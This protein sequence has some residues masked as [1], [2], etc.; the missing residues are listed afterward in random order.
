MRNLAGHTPAPAKLLAFVVPFRIKGVFAALAGAAAIAVLGISPVSPLALGQADATL[1]RGDPREAANRYDQIAA[2]NP[3]PSIRAQAL[4]RAA[5]VWSVEL[6]VPDSARI[7]LERLVRSGISGA[8]LADT[9]EAIGG[10]L[11]DQGELT[12]AGRLYRESWEA[13]PQSPEAADRLIRSAQA[14]E[15]AGDTARADKAWERVI[16]ACPTH[17]ARAELGR[18]EAQL[19]KG[20][21]E[22]ALGRYRAAIAY[23]SDPQLGAVAQLGVAACLERLGNLDEAMAAIEAADLPAEVRESRSLSVRSRGR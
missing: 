19:S 12:D 22:D 1:G 10:L 16:Q 21:V 14:F 17:R 7:R 15:E 2:W 20:N 9:R 8:D 5:T 23:A 6:G 11:E 4:R 3:I 13:D 18:A